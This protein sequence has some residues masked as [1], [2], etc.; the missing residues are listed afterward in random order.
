MI[1]LATILINTD[2]WYR[3]SKNKWPLIFNYLTR[4]LIKFFAVKYFY[5]T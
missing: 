3:V 5:E 2:C 1:F 4:L